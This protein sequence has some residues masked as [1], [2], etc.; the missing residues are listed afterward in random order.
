MQAIHQEAIEAA[1]HFGATGQKI[2]RRPHDASLLAAIDTLGGAGE[3]CG[4]A[5]AHFDE[6]NG[7]AVAHDQIDLAMAA[8]EISRHQGKAALMQV[9]QRQ[10]LRAGPGKAPVCRGITR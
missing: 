5:Q 8:V 4:A 10:V 6:N 7:L 1:W 9:G 3:G 2:A